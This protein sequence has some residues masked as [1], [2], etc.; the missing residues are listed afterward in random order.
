MARAA[1]CLARLHPDLLTLQVVA[2]QGE[3]VEEFGLAT[4]HYWVLG[5][6][7]GSG[8]LPQVYSHPHLLLHSSPHALTLL[9][10]AHE[11]RVHKGLLLLHRRLSTIPAASLP[12]S[13][14]QHPAL[15]ALLPALARAAVHQDTAE[16]R[17]L[18]FACYRLLLGATTL[19]ARWAIV[20]DT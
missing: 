15:T 4:L 19:E 12:P 18:A 5:E 7:E 14:A 17:R 1:A 8:E 16:L 2:E 6:G 13:L 11:I 10:A 9:T 3:Q 20:P